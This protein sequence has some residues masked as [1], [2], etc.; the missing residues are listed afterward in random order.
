MFVIDTN[1]ASELMKPLPRRRLGDAQC[2]GLRRRGGR[3][4]RSLGGGGVMGAVGRPSGFGGI[5]Y[6]AGA[7]VESR[8]GT[9]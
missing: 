4:G 2:S 5:T 9:V 8:S 3:G 7:G 1:V 6:S